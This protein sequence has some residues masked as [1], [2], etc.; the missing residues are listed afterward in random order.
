MQVSSPKAL[1][2]FLR[3]VL[4]GAAVGL[5]G[6]VPGRLGRTSSPGPVVTDAARRRVG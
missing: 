6:T 4:P 2:R 3:C 1:Q 5:H